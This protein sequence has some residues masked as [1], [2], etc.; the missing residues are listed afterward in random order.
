MTAAPSDDPYLSSVLADAEA[1]RVNEGEL[2]DLVD[3][4]GTVV[5]DRVRE[6]RNSLGLTVADLADRIG[7]SKAM[8]SKVENNRASASLST[9]ARLSTALGVPIT[10]FF[11]GLDEEHEV[12]LVKSGQGL[13]ISQEHPKPG[14]D[15]SLLGMMRGQHQ[16]MEPV[17]ITFTEPIE[18]FPLYQHGGS[19]LIYMIYGTMEYGCGRSRFVLEAGDVLQFQGDVSHGATQLMRLPIQFLSI[20]AYGNVNDPVQLSP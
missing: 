15:Y 7:M 12:V 17:L 6:F 13:T 10:A 19:E 16:R 14:S 8:L 5:G 20:K 3:K 9:L 11:R 4:L 1:G 2:E 18:H